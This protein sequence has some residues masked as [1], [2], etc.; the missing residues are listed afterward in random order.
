MSIGEAYAVQ[1][2]AYRAVLESAYPG[3]EV[4]CAIV[5]T[6]GPKLME[7]PPDMLDRALES[8]R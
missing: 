5:W 4:R 8:I 7:L 2:A 1:M 6:D 3:R